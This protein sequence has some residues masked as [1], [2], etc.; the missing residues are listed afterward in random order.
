MLAIAPVVGGLV[1]YG[2][3]L[4][5]LVNRTVLESLIHSDST[6]PFHIVHSWISTCFSCHVHCIL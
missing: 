5:D 4:I 1:L 2:V 3:L 6:S